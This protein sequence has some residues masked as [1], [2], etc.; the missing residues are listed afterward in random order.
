M[1]KSFNRYK[2]PPPGNPSSLEL[3][4]CP[5]Q[6]CGHGSRVKAQAK[7]DLSRREAV[8]ETQVQQLGG[9]VIAIGGHCGENR[10]DTHRPFVPFHFL[11]GGA[12]RVFERHVSMSHFTA[13]LVNQP[14]TKRTAQV[15]A[16]AVGFFRNVV[17]HILGKQTET[18]ILH[19]V[20]GEQTVGQRSL[21]RSCSD[22][23]RRHD[24]F[25]KG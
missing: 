15:H 4:D 1:P 19:R 16:Q 5:L 14:A 10:V 24:R 25:P 11:G 20:G 8:K 9:L 12:W 2:P 22:G 21:R 17:R 3:S 23:I 6:S 18:H 13:Q 7:G